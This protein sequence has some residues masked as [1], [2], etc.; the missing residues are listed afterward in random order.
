MNHSITEKEF[1]AKYC[2]VK[3]S[4]GEILLITT[5]FSLCTFAGYRCTQSA[6]FWGAMC[7]F[8]AFLYG[9]LVCCIEF[10]TFR[11][12]KDYLNKLL[13]SGEFRVILQDLESAEVYSKNYLSLGQHYVFLTRNQPFRYTQIQHVCYK[14]PQS[15]DDHASVEFK[16]YSKQTAISVIYDLT[17]QEFEEL[18]RKLILRGATLT[19]EYRK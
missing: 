2:P 13:P 8:V 5:W 16:L 3:P 18:I 10:H 9:I 15:K 12:N 7:C 6:G 1:I 17:T 19:W 14:N 11:R 4:S